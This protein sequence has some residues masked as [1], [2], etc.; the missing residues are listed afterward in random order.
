[1]ALRPTRVRHTL[2][3]SEEATKSAKE[4]YNA[5]VTSG[6]SMIKLPIVGGDHA[7]FTLAIIAP[8]YIETKTKV[9][10]SNARFQENLNEASLNYILLTLKVTGQQY[11]AIGFYDRDGILWI[12]DGSSRRMSCIIAN[13]PFLVYATYTQLSSQDAKY[14]TRVANAQKQLSLFEQGTLY[15]QMLATEQY[16]NA[17]SLAQGEGVAEST[18]SEARTLA[19]FPTDIVKCIPDI[20]ELGRPGINKLKKVIGWAIKNEKEEELSTQALSLS[21]EILADLVVCNS[22]MLNTDFIDRLVAY[23]MP[24][25]PKKSIEPFVSNGTTKCFIKESKKGLDVKFQD[26]DE[27]KKAAIKAAITEI[28]NTD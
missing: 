7:E 16:P 18:I 10:S 20:G 15:E 5:A 28:L 8:E 4:A 11:P 3:S 13:K 14:L 21:T 27:H 26:L 22:T 9:I 17:K 24:K 23:I 1:M 6:S 12:V 19:R 25:S 2:G